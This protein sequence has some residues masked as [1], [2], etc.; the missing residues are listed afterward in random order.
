[1]KTLKHYQARLN[2]LAE[3]NTRPIAIVLEGR[4]TAGKT[5]TIRQLTQYLNPAWYSV[6][7]SSKPSGRTM[8]NWLE[9]WESR[10]PAPSQIVFYD[11]SWY[12]RALVQSVNGW[13]TDKQYAQFMQSVIAWEQANIP[14]T[15]IKLWLSISEQEQLS[16]VSDRA[17]S[18]LKYWKL[19]PN[20][21]IAVSKYDAMTIKK[22]TMFNHCGNWHSINYDDKESG[23][24]ACIAHIV[25]V[26]EKNKE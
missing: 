3:H 15:I 19:S 26:L 18:P 21:K 7:L 6:C 12:S 23:R 20:D 1:M 11:R 9:F 22:E 2:R 4:D 16:R 8:A 24:L 10:L 14:N 5:G 17:V 25:K 13:C